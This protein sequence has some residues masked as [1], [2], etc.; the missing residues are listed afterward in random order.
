MSKIS[1][2]KVAGLAVGA[3]VAFGAFVPMAGAVT[4]ADLQAQINAL[5]AQ[6]ASLQGG[7]T[8]VATTFTQDLT[9]GSTGAQVSAL[10]QVLVSNGYLTMPA[11]VAM[12]YFGSLTKSAVM[13]WQAASGLPSTGFFGPLSR[14]KLNASASTGT[15]PGTTV[16]GG[17]TAGGSIS[18]PG[19]EGTLTVS[20]YASPASG[21]KL[22]EGAMKVGVLGIKL[23]AK[24]SD[25]RIERVKLNLGT[26]TDIYRKII[27]RIYVMDG[28][29]VLA[30]MDVNSD[31]VVK[32]GSNYY[33]TLA[34]LSYIVPKDSTKNLTIAVDAHDTWDSAF[35]GDSWTITVQ[36]TVC[37]VLTVLVSTSTVLQT[38]ST[39]VSPLKLSLLT[40]QP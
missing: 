5:M 2:A 26:N 19:V 31:T 3:T 1:I 38:A 9:V 24:T 33:I 27:D 16:G 13:K 18:T 17:T 20:K 10:Q 4:V 14:A 34:G 37:V 36:L 22:N 25:I 6:L 11:G 29:T 15:V 12:G 40:K 28:S 30:S 35:N 7:S 39:T 8:A 23:E 21:T 32:D